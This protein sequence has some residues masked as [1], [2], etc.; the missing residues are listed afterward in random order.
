MKIT[1]VVLSIISLG[2]LVY[3]W[4]KGI[5]YMI[6]NHFDYKGEDFLED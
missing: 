3:K 2:Y 5:D 6:N 1:L 4:V